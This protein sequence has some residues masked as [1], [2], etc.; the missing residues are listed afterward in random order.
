VCF[1]NISSG[2]PQ[3]HLYTVMQAVMTDH[4]LIQLHTSSGSQSADDML[5]GLIGIFELCFPGRI[6]AYYAEGSYADRT[7]ITTSDIDLVL[8][9]KDRFVGEDEAGAARRLG[10]YCANLS[11]LELDLDIIDEQ[12]AHRSAFPTLKL[13]SVLLY[14]EDIRAQ[15][16]LPSISDWT[17]DR[18]HAAYWLIVQVFNRSPV[19]RYPLGYPLPDEVFFGYDQRMLRMPDGAQVRCTRDLVR[20][21]GWAATALIA[22]QTDTYVVR[23][24]DCHLRYQELIG[25]QWSELLE[26]IYTRCKH[27]W[28]YR[29]PASLGDQRALRDM[30]TRTLEFENHFLRIFKPFVLGELRGDDAEAR[31][32]AVWLLGQIPYDD[33]AIEQALQE[34]NAWAKQENLL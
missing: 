7:A 22:L 26:V 18:M 25:D 6:R 17:R 14:G 5:C 12:Q 33:Q 8:I 2:V 23:K 31:R 34:T 28:G 24:R 15:L 13:A 32:A 29:I 20:V 19:V 1:S 4:N 9:F 10:A 3:G 16:A 27:E 11:V 30:C 21:T